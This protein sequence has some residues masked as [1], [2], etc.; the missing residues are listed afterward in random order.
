MFCFGP[1]PTF[2]SFDLDLDQVEQYLF[3]SLVQ[4]NQAKISLV[5]LVKVSGK[6][7]TPN[8]ISPADVQGYRISRT[9]WPFQAALNGTFLAFLGAI[10]ILGNKSSLLLPGVKD[11]DRSVHLG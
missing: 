9:F 4:V 7:N 8:Q 11:Q 2:C 3:K 6:Q 5:F 1:I 10:Y